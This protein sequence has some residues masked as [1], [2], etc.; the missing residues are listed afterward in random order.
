MV[1]LALKV[2]DKIFTKCGPGQTYNSCIK[3]YLQVA[4]VISERS[5]KQDFG[6][7]KLSEKI[8]AI[9][10]IILKALSSINLGV[11][12]SHSQSFVELTTILSRLVIISLF[13]LKLRVNV[14]QSI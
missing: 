9:E 14:M 3:F 5:D 2:T 7:D 8:K 4:E 1:K 11:G 6:K 12:P 13:I 10:Q